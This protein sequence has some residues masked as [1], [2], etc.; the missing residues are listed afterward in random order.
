MTR[1][2]ID[3]LLT[4]PAAA[5]REE[6]AELAARAQ[7]E[8]ARRHKLWDILLTARPLVPKSNRGGAM[9]KVLELAEQGLKDLPRVT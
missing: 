3:F 8:E 1:E 9:A 4:H 7:M 5:S 2:R 6:I